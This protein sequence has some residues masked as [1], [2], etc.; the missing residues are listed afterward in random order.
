MDP[1]RFERGWSNALVLLLALL[2]LLLTAGRQQARAGGLEA[3]RPE[4]AT[5]IDPLSGIAIFGYDP[6][7][8]FVSGQAV[9][10][11]PAIEAEAGGAAWRFASRANRAAFLD[12][13]ALYAPA[14][15]GFDPVAAARGLRLAGDPELFAIVAQ[16]LYFF[17]SAAERTGFVARAQAASAASARLSPSA[18]KPCCDQLVQTLR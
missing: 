16:K 4:T 5:I 18:M 15:G 3:L 8:Y 13:P 6:I 9:P 14:D 7:A 10:G 12:Q 1:I 2:L 11:D 17:R